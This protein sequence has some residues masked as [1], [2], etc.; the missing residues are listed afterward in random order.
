VT[1]T[2]KATEEMKSRIL[3]TLEELAKGNH[4]MSSDL[5]SI[6]SIS[7]SELQTRSDALLKNIL[8]NYSFFAITTID[9][10]FQK[11]VRSFAREVGIQTGFKIELDQPKVISDVIDKMLSEMGQDKQLVGWLTDFAIYQIN[12]GNSWD[13]RREIKS[14]SGE[15]FKEFFTLNK[16]KILEHISKPDFMPQFILQLKNKIEAIEGGLVSIGKKI[17]VLLDRNQLTQLDFSYGT[18]GVGG[19]MTKVS[20]GKM[21]LP[22]KRVT[23]AIENSKWYSKKSEAKASIDNA[24]ADGLSEYLTDAVAYVRQH[25]KE[26]QTI[27]Q[28]TKYLYTF[29]L[30]SRISDEINNYREEHDL[31]LIS[32]FPVFL[33]EIIRDSDSHYIFEKVG[34]RYNHYLI[35]EFQD[36]SGLQWNNFRPLIKDTLSAGNFSMVVG[37]IKQSIYRWR[38]GN[39]KILLDQIKVDIGEEYIQ[40]ETL[41]TNRRSKQNI[42]A[43]NNKLFNHAPEILENSLTGKIGEAIEAKLNIRSA[44]KNSEQDLFDESGEGLVDIRFFEKNSVEDSEEYIGSRL[45]EN[46]QTLQDA[47]Y[48]LNDICILVRNNVQARQISSLLMRHQLENKRDGYRYDVLSNESLFLKSNPAIHLVL[49]CLN[50]I[51]APNEKLSEVQLTY[52]LDQYNERMEDEKV[53]S[54]QVV[55]SICM[56]LIHLNVSQMVGKIISKLSLFQKQIDHAYLLAFQDTV[57]DYLQYNQDSLLDFMEWWQEHDTRAVQVSDDLDAIRLMTVHKSKGLQFKVVMIPYCNWKMDHSN[58]EQLMWCETSELETFEKV[59]YV[60]IRYKTDV[61]STVFSDNYYLEK[62]DVFLDNLNLLYVAL[63]RAEEALFIT[64]PMAKAA[65]PNSGIGTVAEVILKHVEDHALVVAGVDGQSNVSLGKLPDFTTYKVETA[66]QISLA[67]SCDSLD[68]DR[69]NFKHHSVLMDEDRIDAISQGDIVHW[70]YSKITTKV[71]FSSAI[72]KA[73]IR[74]GL[75]TEEVLRIK[76]NLRHLWEIP[77]VAGWFSEGWEVKNESSILLS[78]GKMKRPDRVIVKE[79]KAIIIDYKTGEKSSGHIR[80][81]EEYKTILG[82]MGYKNVEGYLLYMSASELVEV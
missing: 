34:T 55:Q 8:H 80:Q 10:F 21:I 69:V 53:L 57:L 3:S 32:D 6:L 75:N 65:K 44:Y 14:L 58:M 46:L 66:N 35:D 54:F 11:V 29:G 31:L 56:E 60:P 42:V 51:Q 64:C 43:F 61:V 38:G 78:N 70:I 76:E 48:Q 47:N 17:K 68:I 30:L 63:T 50:C 4:S 74:Y 28:I 81:V 37:D 45:V 52:A 1:F 40:D 67:T 7:S 9:T 19:Y 39:W 59:P 33:N 62:S 5:M 15:L 41:K 18:G 22:G 79:H 73:T 77:K 72:E 2:N 36:T 26:F 71:D 27:G 23:D 24:L 49:Q 25:N 16:G 82:S 13:T 12:Q 20:E